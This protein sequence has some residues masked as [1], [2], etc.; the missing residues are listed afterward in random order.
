MNNFKKQFHELENKIL[1]QIQKY[2]DNAGSIDKL[3]VLVYGNENTLHSILHRCKK[4]SPYK[5][6]TLLQT[7]EAIQNAMVGGNTKK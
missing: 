7:L 5:I 4:R 2:S 3:S 6:A 1:A